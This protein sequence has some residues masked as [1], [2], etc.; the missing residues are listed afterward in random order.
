MR[1]VVPVLLILGA[2]SD[3]GREPGPTGDEFDVAR[4]VTSSAPCPRFAETKT[5]HTVTILADELLVDGA[6]ASEIQVGPAGADPERGDA[7]NL[8]FTTH[9]AWTSDDGPAAPAI[10]YRLWARAEALTGTAST[11]FAFD[12]ETT[13]MDCTF[14][15]TVTGVRIATQLGL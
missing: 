8:M 2:C 15:W 6:A 10:S 1:H 4:E 7:P 3:S 11:S 14:A 12:T 9:E 5:T 13:A